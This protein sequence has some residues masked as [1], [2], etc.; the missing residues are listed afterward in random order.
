MLV[1]FET[2]F[3]VMQTSIASVWT[4]VSS[5]LTGIVQIVLGDLCGSMFSRRNASAHSTV[6]I[7]VHFQ[8]LQASHITAS[9]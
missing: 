7:T 9:G 6:N 8:Y 2:S 1:D 3:D 5:P 4:C